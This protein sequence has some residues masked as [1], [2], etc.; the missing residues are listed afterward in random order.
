MTHPNLS[1]NQMHQ[2]NLLKMPPYPMTRRLL[3]VKRAYSPRQGRLRLSVSNNIDVLRDKLFTGMKGGQAGGI[4][5][6]RFPM[7]AVPTSEDRLIN[8]ARIREKSRRYMVRRQP[9]SSYSQFR[10]NTRLMWQQRMSNL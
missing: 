6:K 3:P 9:E 4:D 10:R 5:T 7:V 1:L 8:P 2:P